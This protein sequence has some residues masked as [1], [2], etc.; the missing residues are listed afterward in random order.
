MS[1]RKSKIKIGAILFGGAAA[2]FDDVLIGIQ[3]QAKQLSDA[4]CELMINSRCKP[5]IQGQL[6]AIDDMVQDGAQGLIFPPIN[7]I[8][9]VNKINE[10]YK[11]GIPVITTNS[12]VENSHRLCYVGGDY[13]TSGRTAGA[14][15]GMITAGHADIGIISGLNTIK[16]HTDRISGFQEKL[17]K[18]FKDMHIV[19][20]VENLADEFISYNVTHNLLTQY[21]EINGLYIIASGVYGACRAVLDLGLKGKVKIICHDDIPDTKKLIN[22]GIISA[23]ICQEPFKQGALPVKLMFN[24]LTYAIPPKSELYYTNNIIKIK[25]IL[26]SPNAG[27]E[28]EEMNVEYP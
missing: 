8:E 14:L 18:D 4:G 23:T 22:D 13:F 3:S 27:N 21:P 6:Q 9:I 26:E 7:S 2:F 16:C 5:T 24:Y 25:E 1:A 11:K 10:L 28:N 12:D 17:S 19:G 20:I 15:M